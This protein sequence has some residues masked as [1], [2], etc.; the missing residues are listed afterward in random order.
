MLI[1]NKKQPQFL[2]LPT[3]VVFFNQ[4]FHLVFLLPQGRHSQS[5]QATTLE[6]QQ[7]WWKP[8]LP[9]AFLWPTPAGRG[10]RFAVTHGTRICQAPEQ[11]W[12][13]TQPAQSS[14]PPLWVR[15][16]K[17]PSGGSFYSA[18]DLRSIFAPAHICWR[19]S[20]KAIRSVWVKS[21]CLDYQSHHLTHFYVVAP[22][23]SKTKQQVRLKP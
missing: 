22:E 3:L 12:C 18:K 15:T 20:T 19:Q 14:L 4:V 7:S 23:G 9:K 5:V 13:L 6:N 21:Y 8:T 2:P 16:Q 17:L 11:G 10:H 1:P